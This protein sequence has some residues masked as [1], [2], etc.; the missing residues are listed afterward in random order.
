MRHLATF[1][2]SRGL[3]Q[4][5]L[6]DAVYNRFL[7]FCYCGHDCCG[8]ISGGADMSTIKRNKGREYRAVLHYSQNI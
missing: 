5:S 4:K 1:K 3:S 8:C 7:R 6:A 2:A